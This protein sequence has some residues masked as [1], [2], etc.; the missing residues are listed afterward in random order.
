MPLE[1][2]A[3]RLQWARKQHGKYTTPTEAARAFGWKVSTYLGHENGDR[4]PGR[5]SA[6]RYGRMYRVRWEWLLEGEGSPT[7]KPAV[8]LAGYVGEGSEVHREQLGILQDASELPPAVNASTIALEVRGGSMRGIADKGWLLF[9]DDL[10]QPP[11]RDLIDKLCIIELSDG[12]VL[13]RK[14]QPGHKKNCYDL[15]S[16]TEPTLRDQ[17]LRWAARVTWM[18]QR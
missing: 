9:F 10:K 1:T 15:E 4:N 18:R 8:P 16:P 3:E 12:R 11:T 14:V 7:D 13:V 5:E 6:K 2:P 17:R